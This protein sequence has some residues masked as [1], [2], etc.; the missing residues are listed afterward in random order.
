MPVWI[1]LC[2]D[3]CLQ[4]ACGGCHMLVFATPRLGVLEEIDFDEPNDPY[5]NTAASLSAGYLTSGNVLHRTLSARLRR[6]ER[7]QL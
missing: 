5:L 7:V 3:L 4:I 6:R 1:N 2:V